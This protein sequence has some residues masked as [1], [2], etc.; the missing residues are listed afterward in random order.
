MTQTPSWEGVRAQRDEELGS[1]F[2]VQPWYM[3]TCSKKPRPERLKQ[4][5]L[6]V[7]AQR[8]SLRGPDPPDWTRMCGCSAAGGTSSCHGPISWLGHRAA[9]PQ[10][11]IGSFNQLVR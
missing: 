3:M 6:A 4:R 1:Q 5:K 11:N 10:P 7:G 2:Y 9:H 8:E